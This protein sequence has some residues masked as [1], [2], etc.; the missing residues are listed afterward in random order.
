MLASRTTTSTRVFHASAAQLLKRPWKTYKDGT[1]FYGQSKAGNKRLALSTKQGNKNYYKGTRSSGIG[2]M[3]DKGKYSINYS[4]VRT[5]VTP[6]DMSTPLKPLVSAN[7]PVPKNTFKGYTGITDGR[8]WLDKVKEY[9]EHGE[10]NFE[11]TN[12]AVEKY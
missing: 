6:E 9:V 1:L 7:I 11:V 5:F 4:R 3:S 10:V 2:H 8:L 12:T